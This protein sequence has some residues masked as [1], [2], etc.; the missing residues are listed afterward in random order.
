MKKNY[1]EETAKPLF[2]RIA[3][4]IIVEVDKKSLTGPAYL[5]TLWQDFKEIDPLIVRILAKL[6]LSERKPSAGSLYEFL[7]EVN[8][9]EL[10]QQEETRLSYFKLW[11][12][13]EYSKI[14]RAE[15]ILATGES[16]YIFLS[17]KDGSKRYDLELRKKG[18]A[19]Y[20]L[21]IIERGYSF[22][23]NQG[24]FVILK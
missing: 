2:K 22:I 5:Q 19:L 13:I 12:A 10:D 8:W 24:C 17:G 7:E 1:M 4:D 23:F 11:N 9:H 14:I 16:L 6:D 21:R 18:V 3:K 20:A 15:S